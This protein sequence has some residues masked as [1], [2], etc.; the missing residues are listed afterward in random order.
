MN[1]QAATPSRGPQP[2]TLSGIAEPSSTRAPTGSS[3]SGDSETPTACAATTNTTRWPAT[4]AA[5]SSTTA[6]PATA[7]PAEDGQPEPAVRRRQHQHDDQRDL[8]QL[9]EAAL[10][11]HPAPAVP[12]A[13]VHVADDAARQRRV[14]QLGAVVGDVRRPQRHRF[15]QPS[16]EQRPA[17]RAAPRRPGGHHQRHQHRPRA[18]GAQPVDERPG[19]ELPDQ[20]RRGSTAPPSDPQ[21]TTGRSS[22]SV[23]AAMRSRD[24]SQRE[25]RTDRRARHRTP[26]STLA[27]RDV[28]RD[29]VGRVSRRSPADRRSRAAAA[30][31]RASAAAPRPARPGRPGGPAAPGCCRPRRGR[32]PRARRRPSSRSP[33]ARAPA[34]R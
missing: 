27:T 6:P 16:R 4:A 34:P 23:A 22:R 5:E 18:D 7:S 11:E 33:A 8:H 17:G 10:P 14:D 20:E 1:A 13:A 15:A 19:A 29:Q 12:Q 9:A 3:A 30:A 31:P 32:A 28:V 26:S 24:A 2:A 21:P 25:P